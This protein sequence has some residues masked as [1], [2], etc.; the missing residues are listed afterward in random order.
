MGK[1]PSNWEQFYNLPY[2]DHV[3]TFYLLYAVN[4]FIFLPYIISESFFSRQ[5][6]IMWNSLIGY[7]VNLNPIL[8]F[9]LSTLF[10]CSLNAYYMSVF[11]FF[12]SNNLKGL[13]VILSPSGY[14]YNY[15]FISLELLIDISIWSRW[16]LLYWH[17]L[18]TTHPA[19]Y[20]QNLVYVFNDNPLSNALKY[21]NNITLLLNM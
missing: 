1:G 8:I 20:H 4:Y 14:I 9:K 17:L 3:F 10:Q 18:P 13:H 6:D 2:W 16:K 21:L 12:L 11:N 15:Y 7:W 5:A 19:F